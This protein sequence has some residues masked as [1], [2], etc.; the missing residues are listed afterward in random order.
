MTQDQADALLALHAGPGFVIPNAWD[1]GSAR[2]LEQLG[3]AA[4]AT[5]DGALLDIEEAAERLAAARASAPRG[6]FVLNA[7]TDAYFVRGAGDPFEETVERALRYIEAGADSIFVPGVNDEESIRRLVEA[8]PAPLNIVAGLASH[9]I[10]V[11]TLFSLGV[12]RVSLGG[13]LARVAFSALERAGAELAESGTL[14]FLDGVIGYADL[15]RRFG[16]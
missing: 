4:I 1:V 2:L 15:Q 7:R 6:T 12:R 13:S 10:D 5:V 8:I 11:P 16:A 3:F 9:L 14:G